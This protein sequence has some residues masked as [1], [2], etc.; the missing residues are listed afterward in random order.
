MTAT[1]SDVA[2]APLDD[3]SVDAYLRRIGAPRPVRPTLAALRQVHERHVLS[4]PFEN[5]DF[6]LHKP[7]GLG[8]HALPKIVERRRGGGCYELNG[9][10]SEVLRALGYDV[11]VLGG[12][13]A[14]DGVLGPL[15]GHLVLRVVAEDSPQPWLVDVGYGRSFRYPLRMDSR[16]PQADP[17]GNYHIQQAPGGDLDV[18]RNGVHQYRVEMHPRTVEDF[19][20]TL[21][22]FQNAPESP[23]LTGLFCS[24]HTVTG[25][26]TISG[27]TLVRL[28]N[29]ERTKSVLQND[30]QRR[31]AYRAWFG[32]ELG[33]L[34]RPPAP[35][36]GDGR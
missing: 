19:L 34:P 3:V 12:R 27:D 1:V 14:D 15:L 11:T 2:T 9:C 13:V 35:R 16:V 31:E 32:F 21:W 36:S 6:T 26:V 7:I 28:E 23:F 4:V 18:L 8:V 17:Q 20:P 29:G 22:W 24:L 25:K 30:E 5:I 33:E 10:L